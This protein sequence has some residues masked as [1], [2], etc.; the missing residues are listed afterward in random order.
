MTIS[1]STPPAAASEGYAGRVVIRQHDHT[2]T[3]EAW[4]SVDDE[5]AG[6]GW[7]ILFDTHNVVGFDPADLFEVELPGGGRGLFAYCPEPAIPEGLGIGL[8]WA[9]TASPPPSRW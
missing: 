4:V 5:A 1:E 7:R 6:A 3:S 9:P 2:A 8:G